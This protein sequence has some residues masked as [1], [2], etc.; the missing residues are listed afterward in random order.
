[1]AEADPN[2][3]IQ[4]TPLDIDERLRARVTESVIGQANIRHS[5]LNAFLRERLAGTDIAAGALFAEP[6]VEGAGP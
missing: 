2:I 3:V 4:P 1:M 5:E 6:T